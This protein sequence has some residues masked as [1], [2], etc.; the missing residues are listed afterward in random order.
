MF[1]EQRRRQVEGDFAVPSICQGCIESH[2]VAR[3]FWKTA[4]VIPAPP[5]GG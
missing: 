5:G 2:E 1:Q 4:T 3:E